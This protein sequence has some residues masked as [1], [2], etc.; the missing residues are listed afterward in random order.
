MVLTSGKVRK[1]EVMCCSSAGR[2]RGL[3]C[4]AGPAG[5]LPSVPGASQV[6]G[7]FG[8]SSGQEMFLF[9]FFP[10]QKGTGKSQHIRFLQPNCTSD[11]GSWV[12]LAGLHVIR[13]K[14]T[15]LTFLEEEFTSE[16]DPE[17]GLIGMKINKWLRNN[18]SRKKFVKSRVHMK[19]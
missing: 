13:L 11:P 9:L 2:P 3:G 19:K 18:E 8:I 5:A 10:R 6:R 15:F 14:N 4:G 7:S 1:A 12:V 16:K 17:F